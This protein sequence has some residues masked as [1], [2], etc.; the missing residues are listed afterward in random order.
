M[1]INYMFI[2]L[3]CFFTLTNFCLILYS[4]MMPSNIVTYMNSVEKL[5]GTNFAKWKADPKLILVIMDQD[6]SFRD[7]KSIEPVAEGDNDT[8]LE[9]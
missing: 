2:Y 4:V 3:C 5:W 1:L 6:N 8:T 9:V 7:D